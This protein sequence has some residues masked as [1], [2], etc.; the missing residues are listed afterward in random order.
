[1]LPLHS[2]RTWVLLLVFPLLASAHLIDIL[3]GKKECFFEDLHINDKVLCVAG[4]A[5]VDSV[6]DLLCVVDDRYLPGRR[7]W[8]PRR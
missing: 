6:A 2:P 4:L 5:C 3:A 8:T 7:W 1:M